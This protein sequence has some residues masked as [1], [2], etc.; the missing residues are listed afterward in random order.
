MQSVDTAIN[1]LVS[2]TT[3]DQN[4]ADA[5][6]RSQLSDKE[7]ILTELFPDVFKEYSGIADSQRYVTKLN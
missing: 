1:N 6:C 2:K 7:K 3:A 4:K 5:E